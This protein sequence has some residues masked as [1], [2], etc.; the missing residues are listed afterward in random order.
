MRSS[1]GDDVQKLTDNTAYDLHPTWSP[2]GTKIAFVSNRDIDADGVRN[3][4]IYVM[5]STDDG[6][7][8]DEINL[9]N[10]RFND[11]MPSWS[12]AGSPLGNQIAFVSQR[13]APS[14]SPINYEVYR[15]VATSGATATRLTYDNERDLDPAW[16]PV[17]DVIAFSSSRIV[18]G[19][20]YT[21]NAVDGGE[22]T[23]RTDNLVVDAEPTWSPDGEWIAFTH[24]REDGNYDIYLQNLSSGDLINRT[25][26][27][28]I[29]IMPA[30]GPATVKVP[31]IIEDVGFTG[32]NPDIMLD[33]SER[34]LIAFEKWDHV[35]PIACALRTPSWSLTLVTDPDSH[36]GLGY[37]PDLVMDAAGPK[38]IYQIDT[39]PGFKL[40]LSSR[41]GTTWST[42]TTVAPYL[43]QM[44]QGAIDSS[45]VMHVAYIGY[46]DG[47]YN[48]LQYTY[49]A[50]GSWSTPLAPFSMGADAISAIETMGTLIGVAYRATLPAPGFYYAYRSGAT[51]SNSPLAY[52]SGTIVLGSGN[53]VA[54]AAG[55]DGNPQVVYFKPGPGPEPS[56]GEIWY[57]RFSGGSWT[58]PE[59]VTTNGTPSMDLSVASDCTP[60]ICFMKRDATDLF[61]GQLWFGWHATDG[62]WNTSLVADPV[63]YYGAHPSM[64]LDSADRP[65]ITYVDTYTWKIYY[66]TAP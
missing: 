29:D 46:H 54:L 27:P 66:A 1:D 20:I 21:M 33:T 42:P 64:K 51:W 59:C 10:N 11:D 16:S 50:A 36:L 12:R 58:T 4:E 26:N 14:S 25:D 44:G 38:V 24:K 2:D 57:R 8:T 37:L 45:G 32:D 6:V 35:Y 63:G 34:P 47:T 61:H 31:T 60:R 22:L 23:R 56:I 19:E 40:R 53:H 15:M 17:S 3:L 28:A 39:S 41:V 43:S 5:N 55:P 13:D 9:T 48:K 49:G 52:L 18:N 7:H 65:H 30:W 62:S